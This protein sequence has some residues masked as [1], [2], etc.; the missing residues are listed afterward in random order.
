MATYVKHS[1]RAGIPPL[2]K[3]AEYDHWNRAV[4]PGPLDAIMWVKL[5]YVRFPR[6]DANARFRSEEPEPE[7]KGQH[8]KRKRGT[9]SRGKGRAWKRAMARAREKLDIDN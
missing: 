9:R 1:P 3:P 5:A 8:R 6:P 2:V 4:G 7:P